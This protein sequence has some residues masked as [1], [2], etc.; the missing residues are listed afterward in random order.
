MEKD[1]IRK[2]TGIEEIASRI[3]QRSLVKSF[4]DDYIQ[5]DVRKNLRIPVGSDI[6]MF[7]QDEF[8]VVSIDSRRVYLRSNVEAKYVFYSAK[9]GQERIAS[10]SDID[11]EE[12]ISSFES[13]LDATLSVIN[14]ECSG[15]TQKSQ[16]DV[17]M[18]V[19]KLLGYTDIF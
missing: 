3:A 18:L 5:D 13:D 15:L 11:I 9:R 6:L 12:V 8:I 19:S 16:N 10:P 7:R 14:A 4:P 2:D 17:K 1:Q